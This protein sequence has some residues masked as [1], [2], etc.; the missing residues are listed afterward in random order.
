MWSFFPNHIE[1]NFLG[2]TIKEYLKYQK[3]AFGLSIIG[4]LLIFLSSL[5]E[6]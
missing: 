4:Y 5:N 2:L 3:W 1:K 6:R